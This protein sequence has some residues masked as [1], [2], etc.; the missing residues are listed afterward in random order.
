MCQ[1]SV[2][3]ATRVNCTSCTVYGI[4]PSVLFNLHANVTS[5]RNRDATVSI[6]WNRQ[7]RG[8]ERQV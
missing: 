8:K 1:Q 7:D 5:Y 2:T 6:A 3:S 4:I